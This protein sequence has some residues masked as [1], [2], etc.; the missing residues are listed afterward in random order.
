MLDNSW[1]T[2]AVS[3]CKQPLC[4]AQGGVLRYFG[5]WVLVSNRLSQNISL[6]R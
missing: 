2:W 3:Y 5:T 4:L 1:S 6:N